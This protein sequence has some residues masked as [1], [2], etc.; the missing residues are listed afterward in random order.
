M[1][2]LGQ[3]VIGGALR[4]AGVGDGMHLVP[5]VQLPVPLNRKLCQ[6]KSRVRLLIHLCREAQGVT[7]IC[8]YL[9]RTAQHSARCKAAH[10]IR[11]M[12]VDDKIFFKL[13]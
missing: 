3:A 8:G 5:G 12:V 11:F 4:C 1:V 6:Q 7:V 13:V 2:K 9:L 10:A